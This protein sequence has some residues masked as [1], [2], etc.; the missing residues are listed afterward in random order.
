M[1]NMTAAQL[2]QAI[3]NA[4]F[5]VSEASARAMRETEPANIARFTVNAAAARSELQSLEAAQTKANAVQVKAAKVEARPTKS[6][7]AHWAAIKEFFAVCRE[8]GMDA[9][10]K[11]ACRAA[12]G[13][14]LGRR[15][16]T[17]ADLSG[18]EWNFC[19]N[20]VRMGRL[21]W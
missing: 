8:M 5:A 4:R 21:F 16:E 1:Q 15:I 11:P 20:A 9:Q 12:V 10:N 13:M 7:C 14:L 6:R 3:E 17:R 19:T 2:S 18:A